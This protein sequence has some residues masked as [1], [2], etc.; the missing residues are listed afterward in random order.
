[1]ISRGHYTARNGLRQYR[2]CRVTEGV[3]RSGLGIDG[4]TDPFAP[5]DGEDG[6][7]ILAEEEY[8]ELARAVD[9]G[10]RFSLGSLGIELLH[11]LDLLAHEGDRDRAHFTAFGDK[12]LQVL[13]RDVRDDV[14]E[15]VGM[16]HVAVNA[17][18]GPLGH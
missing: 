16:D 15:P 12:G 14:A 3:M 2:F 9:D 8:F 17:V 1:M 4:E 11:A 18:I 10:G 7:G 6:A 5:L 13:V